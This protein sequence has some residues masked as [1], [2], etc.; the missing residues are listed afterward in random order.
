MRRY[1]KIKQLI[2]V[3]ILLSTMLLMLSTI[4][5]TDAPEQESPAAV[6]GT[7]DLSSWDFTKD[8]SVFLNGEWDFY[9]GKLLQPEELPK[10]THYFMKVPGGWDKTKGAF[11]QKSRGN[12]TYRLSVKLP[13]LQEQLGLKI[14]NI[15]MAHRLFING[16]LV[17]ESGLPSDSLEGYQALNTPY[18]VVVEPAEELEIVIQ[19]SN[20]VHFTGGIAHPIQLGLKNYIEKKNMLA[21]GGDMAVFLLF[22]MFGIYHLHMYN[23]RD[24]EKTY[25]FSGLFLLSISIVSITFGE[26]VLMQVFEEIPF[27]VAYKLQDFFLF[28]SFAALTLFIQSLEP[29]TI[30]GRNLILSLMPVLIYLGV[31]ILIPY[32]WYSP[33]KLYITFYAN[34]LLFFYIIRLIYM[35]FYK[36]QGKLPLNESVYIFLCCIFAGVI[37]I[38]YNLYYSGYTNGNMIARLGIFAFLLSLNLFLSRRFT[39]KMNEVQALSEELIRSREIKDE[40]LARTSHELKTPLHGIINIS[41]HLLK[42]ETSS[43]SLEQRENL[44]LI[45]DTSSRLALLVN[46]LIDVIKLRHEDL[47]LNLITVDLYVVIQLVF[48]LLSFDLQGKEVKM[49]NKVKP[50]TFVEADENRLRQILYNITSNAMKHTEKGE[51]VAQAR[52]EGLDIVLTISDTGKGIPQEHWELVFKDF[53]HDS[54]PQQDY[55]QGMGLGLYISRQLARKMKGEVWIADSVVNKGTSMAVRLAKGQCLNTEM[56]AGSVLERK[57]WSSKPTSSGLS[58]KM[59]KILIVDDEPTNI[60]VLSLMLEGEYQVSAAYSGE[61]ALESLKNEKFHLLLTDLMMPGMS[62]IEL[63]QQIRQNYSLIELPIIIATARNREREIELAYQNGANDYITKPFTA[64]EVQWRVRSLLKLTDTMEK[65]FE[66]EM[67]YLQ[68]QIKPH[69]IYN[70]LSNIIALCHEDGEKASEMLSLLSRYLRHIF[71][72]DQNQQ[73]LQLQQELDLIKTYVEIEQLRFGKHLHYETYVDPE[74]LKKGIKIPTLL[75]QPLVENAIRHGLFNKEG[76]GT[77]SLRITE[78]EGFIHIIVEDN[79]VGMSE[80]EVGRILN[81]KGGKGVGLK[82]V[83]MRVASLPKAAFLI[84][85]ELEKGTRCSIFL[86]KELV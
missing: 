20:Q 33:V 77:V 25:L 66:S 37:I 83:L 5:Y 6:Q 70:A 47:Q 40:F 24:K 58:E 44:L 32:H 56:T 53:N 19:V 64:E 9:P 78:G 52:E 18:V 63:T 69:F 3:I 46:D 38:D 50:M 30:K 80:D 61:K 49:L 51:I 45:Q 11:L 82:N 8:R 81:G 72:R 68:A 31:V 7:L 29:G 35:L 75:I 28:A 62:G 79:G 26:K 22:L 59:K 4:Y 23:M 36:K 15:W 48:Q 65:A 76:E 13:E 54:L 1:F 10:E 74:I 39:N 71:Q 17:K 42:G 84:D 57:V 60:R 73:T 27:A 34:L 43:L 67:A 41:G 55:K 14:H 2:A 85:S 16:Q 21:F 86:P 12:G